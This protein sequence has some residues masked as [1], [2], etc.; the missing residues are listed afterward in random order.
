MGRTNSPTLARHGDGLGFIR[1][2]D[3]PSRMLVFW[4]GAASPFKYYVKKISIYY[5]TSNEN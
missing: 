4:D 3:I 5:S 1:T 2:W